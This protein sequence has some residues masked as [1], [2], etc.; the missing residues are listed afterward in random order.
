MALTFKISHKS[1]L[2][3]GNLTRKPVV[4]TGK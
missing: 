2:F 1:L 4:P 3:G